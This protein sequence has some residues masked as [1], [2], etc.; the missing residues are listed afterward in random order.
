MYGDVNYDVFYYLFMSASNEV[1]AW[2][3]C[4]LS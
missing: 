1:R 2:V 4:G 3:K